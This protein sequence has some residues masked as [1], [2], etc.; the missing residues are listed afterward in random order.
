MKFCS[1]C[2]NPL[3]G[4]KFCPKCGSE[5]IENDTD[6]Q[7]SEETVVKQNTPKKSNKALKVSIAVFCLL[8]VC[9][10]GGYF[11]YNKYQTDQAEK[12]KIAEEQKVKEQEEKEKELQ[13]K[14]QKEKDEQEKKAKAEQAEL[15]KSKNVSQTALYALD[16]GRYSQY[17]N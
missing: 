9:S 8:L 15:A 4:E 6:T 12:E 16:N 17:I 14:A 13:E 1:K 10:L 5:I 2:G 7:I 3:N 11:L